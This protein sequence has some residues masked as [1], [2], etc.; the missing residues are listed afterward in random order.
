MFYMY[1]KNEKITLT[2]IFYGPISILM[3]ILSGYF[4]I[5]YIRDLPNVIFNN[6]EIY[7]GKG[8]I[9]SDRSNVFVDIKDHLITFSETQYYVFEE[10]DFECK[11]EYYPVSEEGYSFE[12]LKK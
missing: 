3:I 8:K 6:T 10:G 11:V 9:S 1:K 5:T 12:I 4:L 7:I 2:L